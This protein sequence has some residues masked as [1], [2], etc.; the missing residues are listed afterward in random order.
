MVRYQVRPRGR[1]PIEGL[2]PTLEK[3]LEVIKDFMEREG[4]SPTVYE[5]AEILQISAPSVHAQI[6][7]LEK[8]GYVQR[9]KGKTRSLELL[10]GACQLARQVTL[11]V[12]GRVAAGLPI[13]A[14]ENIIGE[15]AVS[16]S[17]VR[18]ECFALE[19]VGDSM[20]DANINEGDF[21]IVRRQQ[22]A[23]NGDIVVAILEDEATVKRLYIAGDRV[24]LRPANRMYKPIPIGPD[25]RFSIIGKVLAVSAQ[26]LTKKL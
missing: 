3:T 17:D 19:V 7:S 23:E 12:I 20:I 9:T 15:I 25:D 13:L 21:L 10:G 22:I 24:E 11:P 4:M 26:A 8:K 16:S 6:V 2:S 14:V 5:L 18:G 1:P